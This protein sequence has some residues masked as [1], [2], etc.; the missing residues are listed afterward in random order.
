MHLISLL[1]HFNSNLWLVLCFLLPQRIHI[2]FLGY[3]SI[4]WR[5]NHCAEC[6]LPVLLFC[7]FLWLT[8]VFFT[9]MPPLCAMHLKRHLRWFH[10]AFLGS[11]DPG[12]FFKNITWDTG[13]N[14]N[15]R[16]HFIFCSMANILESNFLLAAAWERPCVVVQVLGQYLEDRG[17]YGTLW[18]AFTFY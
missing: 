2:F 15:R 5:F 6:P 1:V 8:S 16:L 7:A 10:I 12:F 18:N 11:L 9:I 3:R 13:S 14:K 17:C 4:K